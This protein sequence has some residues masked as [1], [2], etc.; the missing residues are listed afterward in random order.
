[1]LKKHEKFF[2]A[3][4]CL[5]VILNGCAY[6]KPS[7]V[8]EGKSYCNAG[9]VFTHQWYDYYERALS[10]IE[11]GC[12]Q[13][14][15]SDLD[16][17][18]SARADDKRMAKT[19]GMHLSDYFPHREKGLIYYLSGKDELA[20]TEIE[21][22][23][24]YEKSA[25]ALFYL[26]KV[27]KRMLEK[28]A[29]AVST[30]AISLTESG[31]IWTREMPVIISGNAEDAQYISEINIGKQQVFLEGSSRSVAFE[32]ALILNEGEHE[33]AIT[34]RNLLNGKSARMLK[35]HVDRTGPVI[36]LDSVEADRLQGWL[37][38]ESA[39]VFLSVNGKKYD[40]PKG[41]EAAFSI[42]IAP[43]TAQITLIA[44][45]K[46]GNETKAV[47]E[48]SKLAQQ[49]FAALASD[50]KPV[51]MRESPEIVMDETADGKTVFTE[52]LSIKG[53]IRSSSDITTVFINNVLLYEKRGRFVFFNHPVPLTPGENRITIRAKDSDGKEALRTL[54]VIREIP[55]PFKL[56]YRCMFKPEPFKLYFHRDPADTD[57]HL[58]E[59]FQALLLKGLIA[60]NRFQIAGAASSASRFLLTGYIHHSSTGM[61]IISKITDVHTSELLD[62]ID[63]YG[64]NIKPPEATAAELSE[65]FHKRFPLVRGRITQK[66]GERF[67]INADGEIR[68]IWTLVVGSDT[69]F[70]GDAHIDEK[71]TKGNYRIKLVNGGESAIGDWVITQ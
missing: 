41:K 27:R 71:M 35:I 53:Q 11:G 48:P 15:L 37:Y 58:A 20:K 43:D 51:V 21:L 52:T 22:S 1:M 70:I 61:E 4:V 2:F 14:A 29:A 28:D 39:E 49:R 19:Y 24:R 54:S 5:F 66:H 36:A 12:Y 63:V 17:A 65:K 44:A 7:C 42:P 25:K 62:I 64:E 32:E 30:P 34:A 67:L 10:C 16:N 56:R 26:D 55:E 69:R 8:K 38:D 40:I 45:D 46:L 60:K 6:H 59:K 18:I 57:N 47:I 9:G 3:G 23:L 50:M 68:M 33:I 13:D 31:E